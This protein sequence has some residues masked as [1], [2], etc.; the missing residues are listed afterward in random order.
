MRLAL[1]KSTNAAMPERGNPVHFEPLGFSP[2]RVGLNAHHSD[3]LSAGE[4]ESGK[5][6][7]HYDMKLSTDLCSVSITD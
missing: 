1:H 6:M 4:H 7:P 3:L 5:S 2:L